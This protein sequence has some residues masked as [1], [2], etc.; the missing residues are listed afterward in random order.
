MNIVDLRNIDPL[1]IKKVRNIEKE[2]DPK[3]KIERVSKVEEFYMFNDK[4]FDKSSS[5]DG[6]VVKIA[7][8]A[9]NIH[10]QWTTR[11]Q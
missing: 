11:L 10:Y 7:P 2:K 4:G 6:N 9:S 3:T 1:K 5:S 8:E